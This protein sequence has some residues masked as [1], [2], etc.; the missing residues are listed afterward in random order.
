MATISTLAVNLI[1]RTSVFEKKM[2][3]S[4]KTVKSFKATAASATMG[5]AR[6]ARGLL[7]AAG[8][9]GMG[10]LIKRTMQTIDATGKLSDRLGIATEDLIGLRHAA[11]LAGVSVEQLDKSLEIFVRR[12]GEVKSGSGEAKKGLEALNLQA[13]ELITKSPSESLQIIADKIRMLG[14]QAEK[15]AAAYFL[16]GRSG[17]NLLNLFEEGA[18]GIRRAMQEVE[19]FG[20]AYSRI[21]A[22]RVEEAINAMARMRGILTGVVQVLT[23][24]LAPIIE[25]IT[26]RLIDLSTEGESLGQR[27]SNVV[28]SIGRK[29]AFISNIMS[30]IVGWI[31]VVIGVT[32][33]WLFVLTK[34]AGVLN[35]IALTI[36]EGIINR[37]AISKLGEQLGLEKIDLSILKNLMFEISESFSESANK[38]IKE[39]LMAVRDSILGEGIKS[40]DRLIEEVKKKAEQIKVPKALEEILKKP[41]TGKVKT[42]QFQEI[43]S[44]FIDVAALS[45]A[46]NPTTELV[47]LNQ[48]TDMSNKLLQ[49][50]N[51]RAMGVYQ[52]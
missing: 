17:A 31:K 5:L 4:R 7:L 8:V 13:E 37:L 14:T 41:E 33:K 26:E 40:F 51:R 50:L 48:K 45:P 15:S 19:R 24:E 30:G 23:I 27:L 36:I 42:S 38:N 44:A 43:R 1:A 46:Q 39:G 32:Q 49:E 28:E 20:M 9:G 18:E 34:V 16:F 6:M 29:M 12:M 2:R 25:T 35:T 10:F 11:G 3:T 47:K 22:A 21:D 52:T